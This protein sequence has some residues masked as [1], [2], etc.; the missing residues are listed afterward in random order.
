[1]HSSIV[2]INVLVSESYTW[3]YYTGWATKK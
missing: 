2:Q 1:M 3:V